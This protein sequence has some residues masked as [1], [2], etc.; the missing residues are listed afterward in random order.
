MP[1]CALCHQNEPLRRSHVVPEFFYKPSYDEKHRSWEISSAP[2]TRPR[3]QQKGLRERLLC[4]QCE[5][6]LS[7][8]EKYGKELLFD[9]APAPGSVES[10]L[11]VPGIDYKKFK[12]FQMSLLWRLSIAKSGHYTSIKLHGK[13]EE[14]LRQ[15][16]VRADPGPA[17]EYG[18]IMVFGK[19][20][21]NITGDSVWADGALGPEGDGV[22]TLTAGGIHWVYEIPKVSWAQGALQE[23]GVLPLIHSEEFSRHEVGRLLTPLIYSGNFP[24]DVRR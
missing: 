3:H 18:C 2:N 22:V 4:D 1:N 15:R 9:S 19:K 12:L 16:I 6:H 20:Y 10:A 24:S 7:A 13:Y 23:S 8:F 17:I 21:L 11:L 5:R 14:E